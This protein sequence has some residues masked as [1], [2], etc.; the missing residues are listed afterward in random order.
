MFSIL[1]RQADIY[2]DCKYHRLRD[3]KRSIRPDHKQSPPVITFEIVLPS[4]DVSVRRFG[5]GSLR[6]RI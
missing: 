5:N 6:I 4:K 1:I 3:I 2:H